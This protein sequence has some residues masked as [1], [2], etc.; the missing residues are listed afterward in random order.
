MT[1]RARKQHPIGR[2]TRAKNRLRHV[3]C[4]MFVMFAL[5]ADA[6]IFTGVAPESGFAVVLSNHASADT[7]LLLVAATEPHRAEAAAKPRPPLRTGGR[8]APPHIEQLLARVAREVG[9]SPA[10]LEAV[11][12]AESNFDPLAV[13]PK[14]ALGLMQLMPLTASR[15]GAVDPMAPE[16]NL[17]AGATYLKWLSALF[18]DDTALVLAAYNAGEGAVMRAGRRVPNFPETQAYVPRVMAR[19]L[20]LRAGGCP[21]R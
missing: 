2:S 11:I 18:D 13:S 4:M 10:L 8:K 19:M 12:A 21:A 7:P 1:G 20:C 14:G 17:R 9:I 5:P 6:Q 16:E 3:A 15:F